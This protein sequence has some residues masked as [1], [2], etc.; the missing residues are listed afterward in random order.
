MEG[1]YEVAVDV[2]TRDNFLR[3]NLLWDDQLTSPQLTERY[4]KFK[5]VTFGV[6]PP[7]TW[8]SLYHD[9]LEFEAMIAGSQSSIGRSKSF[10]FHIDLM[11]HS[12]FFH[13]PIPYKPD[14]R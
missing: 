8:P 1:T 14:Q 10:T 9:L 5:D 4:I 11:D 3:K 7:E 13:R 2:A 12:E 6:A